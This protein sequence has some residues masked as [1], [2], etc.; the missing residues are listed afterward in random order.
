MKMMLIGIHCWEI[1][2]GTEVLLAHL[3]PKQ[4]Q[5]FRKRVIKSLSRICLGVSQN[6]QIYIR[7]AKTGK[8]AWDSLMNHFEEKTLLRKIHF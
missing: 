8:E 7:N 4:Q 6:L 1:V 3:T 5:E 2:K